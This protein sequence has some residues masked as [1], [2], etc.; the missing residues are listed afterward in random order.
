MRLPSK[1]A[2]ALLL[3]L[4]SLNLI[5]RFPRT[6]H[7]LG[8]DGFVYHGMTTSLIY[9][10]YA[11]W[12]LTPLSYFGLYPLSHP[13]GSFFFLADLSQVAGTPVEAAILIFDMSL[14]SLGLFFSFV[15]LF[16]FRRD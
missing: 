7:E 14:V 4:L 12:I 16:G 1:T 9:S 13:S 11:E 6:P 5:A 8:F 10:G 15:M 3:F 2:H